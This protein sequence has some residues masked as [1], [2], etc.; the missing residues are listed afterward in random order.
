MG[1]FM[2]VGPCTWHERL[3][4]GLLTAQGRKMSSCRLS[5]FCTASLPDL[6]VRDWFVFGPDFHQVLHALAALWHQS[7]LTRPTKTGSYLQKNTVRGGGG[8]L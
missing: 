3:S 6:K 2:R 4:D 5:G 7:E 1:R 8:F